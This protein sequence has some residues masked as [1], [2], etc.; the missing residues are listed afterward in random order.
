MDNLEARRDSG[1]RR[2]SRDGKDSGDKSFSR[3]GRDSGD[4][5]VRRDRDVWEAP[6]LVDALQEGST[7]GTEGTRKCDRNM[8]EIVHFI[9]IFIS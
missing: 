6:D 3:D 2:F 9:F 5:R 1:D 8:L 7:A 4:R